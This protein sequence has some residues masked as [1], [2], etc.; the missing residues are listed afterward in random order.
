MSARAKI[1][2]FFEKNVGRVVTTHEIRDIAGISDYP[3]RIRELRDEEGMQI[4]SHRDRHD[5]KPGEYIL[6][7]LDRNLVVARAVSPQL[8]IEILARDGYS[9]VLCG[10]NAGDPNP[11]NPKRKVQLHVDHEIPL[12]Q[13]GSNNPDNLRTLCSVCNQGLTN[14]QMPS[15]KAKDLLIRIRRASR[16]VQREVY[17]TLRRKFENG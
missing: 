11:L 16:S 12:S 4:E 6:E 14:V 7:S 17:E 1:R 5:L 8:R 3:R 15:E 13:H 9:C 2:E 10:A